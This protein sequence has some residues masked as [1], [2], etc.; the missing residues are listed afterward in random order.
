MFFISPFVHDP[1]LY[2]LIRSAQHSRVTRLPSFMT[3]NPFIPATKLFIPYIRPTNIQNKPS[4]VHFKE[5]YFQPFIR[6]NFISSQVFE[7]IRIICIMVYKH[8]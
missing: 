5:G 8:I 7:N 4:T 3:Q 6:A 1:V 2:P